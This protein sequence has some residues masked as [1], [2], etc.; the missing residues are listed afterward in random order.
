MKHFQNLKLGTKLGGSY[1][2]LVLLIALCVVISWMGLAKVDQHAD[3]LTH[4]LWPKVKLSQSV[5][6]LIN[7]SAQD[8]LATMYLDDPTLIHA[9]IKR[10]TAKAASTTPNLP[11]I[12]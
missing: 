12:C 6:N 2:L 10:I 1:A 4:E 9:E 11:S 3:S 7:D 8:L 5:I